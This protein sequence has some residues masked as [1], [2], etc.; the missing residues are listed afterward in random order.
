MTLK[1]AAA[2]CLGICA[3]HGTHGDAK[4]IGEIA[5][6]RQAV[7]GLQL[8]GMEVRCD[9]IGNGAIAWANMM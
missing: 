7:A 6:G 1:E 3:G 8:P 2:L 5:V 9:G 4:T